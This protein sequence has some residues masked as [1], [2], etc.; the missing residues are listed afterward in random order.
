[1]TFQY[2]NSGG[3]MKALILAAT[4]VGLLAVTGATEPKRLQSVQAGS[5]AAENYQP[6]IDELKSKLAAVETKVNSME[7]RVSALE[8]RLGSANPAEN[9]KQIDGHRAEISDLKKRVADLEANLKPAAPAG[10]KRLQ[11]KQN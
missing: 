3:F 1:M 6:Q 4:L 2:P 10:P 11:S 9:G 5:P 8:A 7:T